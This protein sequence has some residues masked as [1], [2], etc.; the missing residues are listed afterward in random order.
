M[1]ARRTGFFAFGPA[2]IVARLFGRH[3]PDRPGGARAALWC[4]AVQAAGPLAKGL[5]A[6]PYV[7]PV[8][9]IVANAGFSP[10]FPA[11]GL[12]AVC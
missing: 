6:S 10:V 12:E 8:D 11:L 5:A 9:A 2:L 7:A 3:L 4:L 1:G